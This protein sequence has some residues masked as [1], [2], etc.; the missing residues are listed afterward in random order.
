LLF[1]N[2]LIL[3]EKACEKEV[4]FKKKKKEM[5][6]RGAKFCARTRDDTG[7]FSLVNLWG[8]EISSRRYLGYGG[9]I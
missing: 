5:M 6:E 1:F 3:Q 4:Y 2:T 9:E 7:T 8:C